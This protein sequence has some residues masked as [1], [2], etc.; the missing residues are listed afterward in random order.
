MK[1]WYR[2]Q[3]KENKPKAA[4]I[5]IYD[6]IG[7]WG[8][9][10]SAFM[11]DLKSMGE[12]DEINLSIHSPG[13]DVLDGWAI[14]NALKN[15]K[16]KVT[17]RVEGLAASMASVILMAAD[18]IE[19]PENAYVMIHNPW[20]VAIG[21]A[22]ELRDTAELLDKLGN[23]LVNA[24]ASRTGND[25]DE[26]REMM[27]AE[28]WMDGK[29]AVE[30]GFADTL[31]NGVALSA[32]AFD[33]RKFRMTPNAIQANS[34]SPEQVAPVE[35]TP[36]TAPVESPTPV[37]AEVETVV[38][39]T[40]AVTE[41]ETAPQASLIQRAIAAL[42]GRPD[43]T[44]I[45]AQLAEAQSLNATLQANVAS[46]TARVAELEPLAR[47]RDELVA[48][49]QTA[50]Q[51]A[52]AIVASVGFTPTTEEQLPQ[53]DGDKGDILEQYNAI[54]DPAERTKFYRENQKAL[55]TA[56]FKSQS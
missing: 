31:L 7:M 22:E 30:R 12:L 10:A 43:T 45:Q 53:A 46:L 19:I 11:R 38:E 44:E 34:E 56:Q 32:R 8:V 52:A 21:D 5:S 51:R 47:E 55:R 17:A 6:E 33:T 4:D 27:S 48:A 35:V 15:N 36:I 9:S 2:I 50:E 26:I 49:I 14:Y 16:A 13:G 37:E 42:T 24:Y 25:E 54:T 29:E 3:A 1:T 39:E 40:P 23:G 41:T 28:T 20:G 18:E